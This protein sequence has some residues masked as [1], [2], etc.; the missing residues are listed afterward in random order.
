MALTETEEAI[1][2]RVRQDVGDNPTDSE[3]VADTSLQIWTDDEHLVQV[4]SVLRTVFKGRK[5][6]STLSD[7]DLEVLVLATCVKLN[8]I[9][10]QDSARY[11][12]YKIRDV[13]VQKLSPSEF[14][15]IA[16]ALEKRLDKLIAESGEAVAGVGDNV[17]VS[18]VRR[19]DRREAAMTPTRY[20]PP[21]PIPS[22]RLE[23]VSTGVQISIDYM[24]INDYGLHYLKRMTGSSGDSGTVIKNYNILE[25]TVYIDTDAV[26][27]TTYRYRLYVEDI[28]GNYTYEEKSISYAAP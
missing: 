28:N 5:T 13:D 2:L 7:L 27:G 10:A 20:A 9:L 21:K 26:D 12:K 25:N 16:E 8:Y 18:V 11:V 19:F 15:K 14:L 4:N 3:G 1:V 22:W 24:F 17:I 23:S 6:L